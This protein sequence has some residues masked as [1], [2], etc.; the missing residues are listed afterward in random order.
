MNQITSQVMQL[1]RVVSSQI[2]SEGQDSDVG[3]NKTSK[4]PRKSVK[5]AVTPRAKVNKQ[6]KLLN[7]A[8][9]SVV[10]SATGNRQPGKKNLST[11]GEPLMKRQKVVNLSTNSL[12]CQ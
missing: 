12:E 3:P 7:P 5:P 1:V 6:I 11:D 8:G 2:E 9:I 10:L 4:R